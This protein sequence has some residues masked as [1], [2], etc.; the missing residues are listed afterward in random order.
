MKEKL[1]F[2]IPDFF[3][4]FFVFFWVILIAVIIFFIIVVFVIFKLLRSNVNTTRNRAEGFKNPYIK[5]DVTNSKT[6]EKEVGEISKGENTK[7]LR[8][9][10][11]NQP[12]EEN[13][14][15]CSYC[16]ERIKK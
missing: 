9:A 7:T 1:L 12:V 16:G 11:C 14:K 6:T 8:C 10:Y 13:E 5:S 15:F 4:G 2:S 3:G